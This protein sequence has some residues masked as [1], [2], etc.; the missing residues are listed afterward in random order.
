VTVRE[1]RGG[2]AGV[3]LRRFLSWVVPA[4]VVRSGVLVG[5]GFLAGV[6][7]SEDLTTRPW[8]LAAGGLAIGALLIVGRAVTTRLAP[9]YRDR[10]YRKGA[11]TS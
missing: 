10:A 1:V 2:L 7:F 4:T 11:A 3:D 5:I 8:L 6:R 9:A